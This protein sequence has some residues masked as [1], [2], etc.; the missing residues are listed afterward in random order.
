MPLVF[1]YKEVERPGSNQKVRVPALIVTFIG[2]AGS[3]D[4]TCIVDSG[5]DISIISKEMAEGLGLELTG[6]TD[7]AYGVGGRVQTMNSHVTISFGNEHT[8][9]RLAIP[10]KAIMDDY[11]MPPLLGRKGFFEKYQVTIDEKKRRV[12]LKEHVLIEN[13]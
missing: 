4:T 3:F 10:L 6:A 1:K 9:Q 12:E 11:Q 13:R 7:F 2:P 8:R 5:A